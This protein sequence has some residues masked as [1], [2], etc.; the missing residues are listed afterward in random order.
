MERRQVSQSAST[1][2]NA[3]PPLDETLHMH[4]AI[5]CMLLALMLY[6]QTAASLELDFYNNFEAGLEMNCRGDCPTVASDYARED[7]SSMRSYINRNTGRTAYRAEA[8]IPGPEKKMT[9]NRHYWYGFSTYLPENWQVTYKNESIANFHSTLDPEDPKIGP[10]FTIRSGRGGHWEIE[11]KAE[12]DSRAPGLVWTL[13]SVFDDIGK[14]T[15]WVVHYKPSTGA[16]GVLKVWK[17]GT[18]VAERYGKNTYKDAVGPYFKMGIYQP[19]WK[20]RDCCDP[21]I[22]DKTV[23]HDALRIASSAQ[24]RYHHVAPRGPRPVE[25]PITEHVR[26]N[27]PGSI[28]IVN[29]AA[30]QVISTRVQVLIEAEDPDGI[31]RVILRAN[32]VLV[33]EDTSPPWS[34]TLEPD[35]YAGPNAAKLH[36]KAVVT[37]LYG[38]KQK[39]I[40]RV[41]T[42]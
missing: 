8:V 3:M 12:G 5:G 31:D 34:F 17:N 41:L 28:E 19:A 29:L 25:V 7:S 27:Q 24:A 36:L 21:A 15:D 4:L 2:H 33:G 39:H 9:F 16:Q 13:N 10:P 32:N 20:D 30:D 23:Y 18:L 11:S 14:W 1:I 38:E 42:D 37:D 22:Y 26:E 35:A 40:L 6:P